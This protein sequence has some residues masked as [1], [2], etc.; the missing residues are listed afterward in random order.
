MMS[1]SAFYDRVQNMN[2]TGNVTEEDLISP[3]IGLYCSMNVYEA[4]RQDRAADKTKGKRRKRAAKEAVCEYDP[5][6]RVLR[7]TDKYSGPAATAAM[8][9]ANEA[10]KAAAAS[11]SGSGGGSRGGPAGGSA[12]A[13]EVE[14]DAEDRSIMDGDSDDNEHG[15]RSPYQARRPGNKT[16]RQERQVE[17]TTVRA[18][19]DGNDAMKEFANAVRDRSDMALLSTAEM[20]HT[21]EAALLRHAQARSILRRLRLVLDRPGGSSTGGDTGREPTPSPSFPPDS[22]PHESPPPSSPPQVSLPDAPVPVPAALS[23]RGRAAHLTKQRAVIAVPD[24]ELGT[25][26]Q[27]GATPATLTSQQMCNISEA[28]IPVRPLP[29]PPSV[30]RP[31]RHPQRQGRVPLE[32]LVEIAG[33]LAPPATL[34]DGYLLVEEDVYEF[35]DL[36]L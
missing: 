11:A 19:K 32:T 17:I 12:A 30:G 2:L 5:C 7:D 6:W 8:A 13:S 4:I 27:M 33:S 18:L 14:N 9:A 22:P 34:P 21:A 28:P 10:G 23:S 26:L 25:N 20:R 24:N 36:S 15:Q 16:A 3:A 35:D 29:A 1:F 31:H